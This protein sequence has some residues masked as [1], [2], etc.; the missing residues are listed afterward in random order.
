MCGYACVGCGRCGKKPDRILP[1]FRC[2]A[3][4]GPVEA[5]AAACPACGLSLVPGEPLGVRR[6]TLGDGQAEA[7]D[8][9]T[10]SSPA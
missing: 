6:E 5:G 1:P 3:C 4:G 8:D 10:A 2:P 7:G 9:A